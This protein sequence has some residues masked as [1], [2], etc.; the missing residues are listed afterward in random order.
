MKENVG[1]LMLPLRTVGSARKRSA[2]III[3]PVSAFEQM[4]V[5][6]IPMPLEVLLL[7]PP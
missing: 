1:G 7:L 4:T 5:Q 2:Y 6:W 3:P